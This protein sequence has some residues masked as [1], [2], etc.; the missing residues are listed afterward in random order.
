M[1]A[2]PPGRAGLPAV[3]ILVDQRI[4]AVT[5][6]AG[7]YRARAVRT[8]WHRVAARRIGYRGVV[9]DSVF[10]P[11]G[12]TVTVDFDLEANPLDLEPLVVTAP[13]DAMLDPLATSTE[14]RIS[15]DSTGDSLVGLPNGSR[16]PNTS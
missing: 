1:T 5:D 15:A 4:G 2:I 7:R 13:Y 14:Q 11:A 3:E 8:G 6:T 9:L 10:V 16:L 12:T